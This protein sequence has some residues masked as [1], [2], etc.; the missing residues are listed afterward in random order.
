MAAVIRGLVER[1]L[2]NEGRPAVAEES[3]AE[4]PD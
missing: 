1:F 2:S 4:P 3:G